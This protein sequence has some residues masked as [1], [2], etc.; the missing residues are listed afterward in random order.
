MMQMY[1]NAR[2]QSREDSAFGGGFANVREMDYGRG[3]AGDAGVQTAETTPTGD[4]FAKNWLM[5]A[6]VLFLFLYTVSR[7]LD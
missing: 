2:V 5:L 7:V 3:Q 1:A 4:P 6:A